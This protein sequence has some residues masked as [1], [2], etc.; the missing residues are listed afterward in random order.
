[1]KKHRKPYRALQKEVECAQHEFDKHVRIYRRRWERDQVGQLEKA[2]TDNPT[3]FWEHIKRM[4]RKPKPTVPCEVYGEDGHVI[5]DLESVMNTWANDFSSLFTPPPE[6]MEER[7]HYEYIKAWNEQFERLDKIGPFRE[8]NADFSLEEVRK[9]VFQSKNNKA[10][11][12][13]GLV[14][15][16]FKNDKSV[17]LLTVLYNSC[18]K[19]GLLPS[20]WL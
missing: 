9:A 12:V 7:E 6:T 13:D 14:Y 17:E 1:M 3:E 2:N 19:T 11:G 8:Y 16:L 5:T 15:E 10:A 4:G 20:M 18:M